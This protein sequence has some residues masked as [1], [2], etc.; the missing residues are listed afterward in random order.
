MSKI[1]TYQAGVAQAAAHRSLQKYCDDV[2]APYGITKMHWL[3]IGTIMDGG[4]K[5]VRISDLAVELGTTMGFLSNN[6]K[7]LE[8]QGIIK[9]VE[10]GTD[11]R[12]RLVKVT[13][14]FAAKCPKIEKAL[15]EGLRNT[16][17]AE[18]NPDDFRTYIKVLYQ[19]KAATLP[20]SK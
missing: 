4:S 18:V 19:L 5:G 20:K 7:V 8:K 3:M 15:R 1:T 14:Q 12:S 6:L 13:A 2:L 11:N 10:S 17:Y 9:R 16:I